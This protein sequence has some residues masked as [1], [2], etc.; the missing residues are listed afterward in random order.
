MVEVFRTR[1]KLPHPEE[2]SEGLA[3]TLRFDNWLE[4]FSIVLRKL[5][6]LNILFCDADSTVVFFSLH[7]LHHKLLTSRI[8]VPIAFTFNPCHVSLLEGS[9][10]K[11][12]IPVPC[13]RSCTN[14]LRLGSSFWPSRATNSN[15]SWTKPVVSHQNYQSS[16]IA[17][18][19]AQTSAGT[20]ALHFRLPVDSMENGP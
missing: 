10:S 6:C 16:H 18:A 12:V 8:A 5:L 19:S 2:Y 7:E 17:C 4:L 9:L 1:N 20:K 14:H 13:Q 11:F 15:P 3:V